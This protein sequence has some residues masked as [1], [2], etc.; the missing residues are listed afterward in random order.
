MALYQPVAPES[1]VAWVP[2]NESWG[3]PDLPLAEEQRAYVRGIYQLTKAIDPTR[4]VVANSGWEA[5]AG[6]M[7][8]I[9]D[10]ESNP[11]RFAARYADTDEAF[12][13]L[14]KRIRPGGKLLLLDGA[15]VGDKPL[16]IDEMGGV[17][18]SPGAKP[19]DGSWGY[20]Q[21]ATPEELLERYGRLIQI[22]RDHPRITGFCWTQL[23][24]TYQEANG[25]LFMDRTPKIDLGKLRAV[26]HGWLTF[27]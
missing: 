8:T 17:K 9:H 14:L 2:F 21:V 10:Y 13:A 11:A 16:L 4:P 1:I 18:Y 12:A 26:N 5:V 20:S 7:F 19:D 24:D 27:A 6:D 15:E 25:L 3:L 22:L 23:T